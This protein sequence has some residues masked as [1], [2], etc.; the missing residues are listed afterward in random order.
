MPAGGALAVDR[1]RFAAWIDD[2]VH[3]HPG[4]EIVSGEVT[5]FPAGPCILS[6]GPLTSGALADRIRELNERRS[7]GPFPTWPVSQSVAGERAA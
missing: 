2:A 6:T 7:V 4:I 1:E 5:D 3:A